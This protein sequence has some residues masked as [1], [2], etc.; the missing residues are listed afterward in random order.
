M[1][2]TFIEHFNLARRAAVP[3]VAVRT[4]DNEATMRTI[5]LNKDNINSPMILQDCVRGLIAVNDPGKSL[6]RQLAPNAD[7]QREFANPV[8]ALVKA[9]KMTEGSILFMANLHRFLNN[10][11]VIQAIWNLRAALK[12]NSRMLV[13]LCPDITLP[14]EIV[15]DVLVLD[16]PLPDATQLAG[17]VGETY[18]AVNQP[19]PSEE[20][21]SRAVDALC[22]LA[23]FSAEQVCAMSIRKNGMDLDQLWERKRQQ[24][25]QTPGLNVWRGQ[26]R[27]ADIGGCGNIKKFLTSVMNGKDR[28]RAI[29]FQDEIEKQFA[30]AQGD[31]SGTTQELLGAQLSFMQDNNSTG[32]MYIGHPGVAKSDIAKAF[33]NEAGVPTIQLDLGAAKGS[34]VGESNAN[35]RNIL[36]VI[37]AV[38]QGRAIWVATCNDITSLPPELRRRYSF[39]TFFFDLPTPSERNVIWNIYFEKYGLEEKQRGETP[40]DTGWTGA[41]I[42]NCC[43]IAYRLGIPLKE[44]ATYIVPISVSASE[45]ITGLRKEA[46]GRYI[47]AAVPGPYKA[48]AGMDDVETDQMI[49]AVDIIPGKRKIRTEGGGSGGSKAVN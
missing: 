27:F 42:K 47:S 23:A 37:E 29:V 45:R 25:E 38:S 10:E 1:A 11:Q 17:I 32:I 18:S 49:V 9:E 39:G 4:P 2:R 30:G 13:I 34:L 41:E 7:A 22:G 3:L 19:K 6:V 44:A 15:Q 14:P 48:P 8:E 16:E 43:L 12:T 5:S 26:Q 36:K 28:P 46:N 40:L 33:G 20:I 35:M 24:I 31:L 21:M